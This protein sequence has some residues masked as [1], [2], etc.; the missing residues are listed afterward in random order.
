MKVSAQQQLQLSRVQQLWLLLALLVA[1]LPIWFFLPIWVAFGTLVAI[2]WRARLLYKGKTRPKPW[3]I[4]LIAATLIAATL[5][6]FGWPPLGVEPLSGILTAAAGLKFLEMNRRQDSKKLIYL[7][8]FIAAIQPVFAQ[9]FGSFILTLISITVILTAQSMLL[10]DSNQQFSFFQFSFEPLR[11]V[12]RLAMVSI[13]LTFLIFVL[14]PRLPAF[15]VLPVQVDQATTGI[16]D[17]MDPGSISSLSNSNEVALR[18]D[19]NGE[20][21]SPRDLYWRGLV[22]TDFDGRAWQPANERRSVQDGQAIIWNDRR[23]GVDWRGETQLLGER[24]EYTVYLEPTNEDWLFA[25]PAAST[26]RLATGQARNLR[27]INRIPVT[28]PLKYDVVS[29]LDY[30]HQASVLSPDQILEN[31]DYAPGLNPQTEA[32]VEAWV[33]E[34]G[35]SVVPQNILNLFNR[36][37]TYTLDPPTYPGAAVD[38]FLFEG[39]RG[40]CE[41]FASAAAAMLRMAGIPSRIVAGYQGGELHPAEGYLIVHQYNAHAWVEYWVAGQGWIRL[42]PTAAVAPERIESGFE[43]FFRSSNSVDDTS[44]DRFRD[45]PIANWL[46][47]QWDSLNYRWLSAVLGY[48]SGTQFDLLEG[49]MGEV[50]PLKIGLM[51]VGIFSAFVILYLFIKYYLMAPKVEDKQRLVNLFKNRLRR[52][53]ITVTPGMTLQDIMSLALVKMPEQKDK[54][55]LITAELD[56]MLYQLSSVNAERL[57]EEIL[58]LKPAP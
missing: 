53:G 43:A 45:F 27:L 29:Y 1:C 52:L 2:S 6:Q 28:Q 5:L 16:S 17:F 20:V 23:F 4:T 18:V 22:F 32:L 33:E 12:M 13:P 56:K 54:I 14:A 55:L 42:D 7:C 31:L 26:D 48:D 24:I 21:P 44:F 10:R 50:T 35:I 40:F 57:K 8:L 3:I 36:E 51:L 49:I 25:M 41:H 39:Q 38:Q 46:R 9:N 11:Q 34:S 58:S 19:F 15:S 47:L 37:F 30:Q